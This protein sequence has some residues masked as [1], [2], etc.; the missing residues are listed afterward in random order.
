[1]LWG[2]VTYGAALAAVAVEED[3][4]VAGIV[5][6]IAEDLIIRRTIN[7]NHFPYSKLTK[8][9]I[10]FYVERIIADD[11]VTALGIKV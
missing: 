2:L 6:F 9:K 5:D 1:M 11:V 10:A 7:S 4:A 8:R 3:A